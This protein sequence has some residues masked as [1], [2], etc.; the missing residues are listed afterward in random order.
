M[1]RTPQIGECADYAGMICRRF[2]PGDSACQQFGGKHRCLLDQREMADHKL[3][4]E[5]DAILFATG[6]LPEDF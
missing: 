3:S 5:D 4:P 2:Y 6:H 1:T